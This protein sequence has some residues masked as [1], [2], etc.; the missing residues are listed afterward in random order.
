MTITMEKGYEICNMKCKEPVEVKV[1]VTVTRELARCKLGLE[2]RA[3]FSA[4][5]RPY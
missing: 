4:V 3:A 1:T 5:E 2:L